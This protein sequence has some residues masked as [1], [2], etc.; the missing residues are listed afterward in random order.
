MNRIDRDAIRKE[1]KG[2]SLTN[3]SQHGFIYKK[4]KSHKFDTTV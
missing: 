4:V 1:V 2:S 3:E